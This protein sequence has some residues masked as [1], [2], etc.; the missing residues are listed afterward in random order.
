MYNIIIEFKDGT[1]WT[2]RHV[3]KIEFHDNDAI[4]IFDSK[5]SIPYFPNQGEEQIER[6]TITLDR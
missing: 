3:T 4:D 6:I 1:Q 2:G 5:D